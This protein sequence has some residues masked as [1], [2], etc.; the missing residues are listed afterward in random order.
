[1]LRNV[2]EWTKD[3][4]K[5]LTSYLPAYLTATTSTLERFY[6]DGFAG[7]GLNRLASTGELVDGSPL[8]ALDALAS[9]GTKFTKLFFI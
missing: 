9:N 1:M 4:L 5:I 6:I 3:K 8:I 7:P 2:G